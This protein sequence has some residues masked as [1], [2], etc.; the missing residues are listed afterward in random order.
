MDIEVQFPVAGRRLDLA[1]VHSGERPLKLDIE[2][3]GDLY[4]RNP[5]GSRKDEDIWRDYQLKGLGWRVKRFWVY[6]LR[7]NLD[8]CVESILEIWRS[9]NELP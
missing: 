1:I 6:Q 9:A 7:E 5:D 2:V 3:D 4:H 8:E